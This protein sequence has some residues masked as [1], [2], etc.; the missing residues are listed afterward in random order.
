MNPDA[1]AAM[2]AIQWMIDRV[3][4]PFNSVRCSTGWTTAKP[5]HQNQANQKNSQR[6]RPQLFYKKRKQE[7]SRTQKQ[8]NEDSFQNAYC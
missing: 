7:Q 5:K 4:Q 3:Q 1:L 6:K 8:E 2:A